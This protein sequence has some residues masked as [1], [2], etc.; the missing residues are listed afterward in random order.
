MRKAQGLALTLSGPLNIISGLFTPVVWFLTISTNL[1]LRC[2]GIDPNQTGDDVKEDDMLLMADTSDD[3]SDAE[4]RMIQNVFEFNDIAAKEFATHRTEVEVLWED[5]EL[6]VWDAIIRTSFHKNYPVCKDTT[7]NIIGVLNIKPYFQMEHK[8]KERVLQECLSK[9]YMVPETV[10]ADLLFQQMKQSKKC[11]A[12]VLDEYGGVNGVVTFDDILE[13]IVGGFNEDTPEDADENITRIDD[14][15]WKVMG[16]T[17]LDEVNA[18][19]HT[20]FPE[21]EYETFGGLVLGHYGSVPDDETTLTIQIQE[22][23]VEVI[24]IR[25][26]K[27]A[28]TYVTVQTHNIDKS[29][30]DT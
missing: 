30:S 20:N 11:F 6:E 25:D 13:Q 12:I 15:K 8:T 29:E 14:V 1:V 4:K 5:D 21:E 22:L 23:S 7:D 3:I 9:P 28:E 19:L 16:I 24:A 10:K 18:R 27:I 17:P 2:I 26:H